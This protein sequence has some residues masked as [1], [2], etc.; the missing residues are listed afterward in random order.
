MTC[1][2]V[3]AMME[4]RAI[5]YEVMTPFLAKVTKKVIVVINFQ[6]EKR[7]CGVCGLHLGNVRIMR[8][9]V[10]DL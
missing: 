8:L 7:C 1:V 4:H 3:P 2:K 5:E 9:S 10:R 6:H